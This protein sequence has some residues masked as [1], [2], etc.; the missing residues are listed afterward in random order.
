MA[1]DD[2]L[3]NPQTKPHAALL[4]L[5]IRH[6]HKP[7]EECLFTTRRNAWSFILYP[8]RYLLLT[9]LTTDGDGRSTGANLLALASRLTKTCVTRAVSPL[10]EGI[11]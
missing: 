10:G 3:G 1:L 6:P 9:D 2:V 5:T 8:D 7:L 11:G 4:R